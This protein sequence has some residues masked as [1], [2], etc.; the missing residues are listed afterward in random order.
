MNINKSKDDNDE[1]GVDGSDKDD[2]VVEQA[3]VVQGNEE[4]NDQFLRAFASSQHV[5]GGNVARLILTRIG[6]MNLKRRKKMSSLRW[7][8]EVNKEQG[9]MRPRLRIERHI[10]GALRVSLN[11]DFILEFKG[12]SQ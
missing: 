12:Y 5:M 10:F 2:N 9:A 8:L 7:Y 4:N 3:I 11:E 1:W 6:L